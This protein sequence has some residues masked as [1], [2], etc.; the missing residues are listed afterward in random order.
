MKTLIYPTGGEIPVEYKVK[1]Q[2]RLDQHQ[3]KMIVYVANIIN[4]CILGNDILNI[5]GLAETV[6]KIF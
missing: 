4:D 2:V 5:T 6:Y 1:A 3:T